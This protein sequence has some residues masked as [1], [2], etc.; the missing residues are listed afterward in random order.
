VPA[1][2]AATPAP[3]QP[4]CTLPVSVR[5]APFA[6]QARV[7]QLAVHQLG[8]CGAR[9][10]RKVCACVEH[11]AHR[12]ASGEAAACCC[13]AYADAGRSGA[14]AG[15]WW[16]GLHAGHSGGAPAPSPGGP[17]RSAWAAVVGQFGSG[18][19]PAGAPRAAGAAGAC[20]DRRPPGQ[21]AA[22]QASHPGQPT[23]SLLLM[24]R[25]RDSLRLGLCLPRTQRRARLAADRLD[26]M[27]R[28]GWGQAEPAR[29]RARERPA[30]RPAAARGARRALRRA[31]A[32][33]AGARPPSRGRSRRPARR[34]PREHGAQP[35][36]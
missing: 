34:L 9:R 18:P 24:L 4:A 14:E 13:A 6:T 21:S 32:R 35:S 17:A 2:P 1:L 19:A 28:L 5:R 16:G 23:R 3:Q 8:C 22:V 12:Q 36:A 11:A 10:R 20:P 33:G 26:E 27:K 7:L 29:R 15:G 31:G 30:A 25:R